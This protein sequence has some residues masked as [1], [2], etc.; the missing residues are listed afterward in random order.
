MTV[1]ILKIK[2]N[3]NDSVF[4]EPER[5]SD[6][7]NKMIAMLVCVLLLIGV[8]P[9]TV[10]AQSSDDIIIL[11][12]NDVHCAVEGYAKLAAMKQEFLQTHN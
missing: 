7:K 4:C 12:E 8:V 6:M 5:I 2:F 3:R 11:Y 9:M 1:D 10:F